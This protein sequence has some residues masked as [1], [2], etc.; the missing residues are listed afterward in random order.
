MEPVL[1]RRFLSGL[2]RTG[3]LLAA[4]GVA[5]WF[6][7]IG[8]VGGKLVYERGLGVPQRATTRGVPPAATE[9]AELAPV[10]QY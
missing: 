3:A 1:R 9:R 5:Y 4:V 2:G 6:S 7:L 8:H 10:D